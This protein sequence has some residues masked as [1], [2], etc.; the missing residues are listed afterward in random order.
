MC[1]IAGILDLDGAPVPQEQIAAMTACLAHRGPDDERF[2]V[3]GN[4]A[5]GHTRL[6]IIDPNGSFQ[7]MSSA[8]GRFSIT[9]NGEILNYRQLRR[10]LDYPFSTDGD[11]E[12]LLALFARYGPQGA[13][14]LRGQYAYAVYDR[15]T[16]ELHLVRDRL[17]ILPLYYVPDGR[18]ILFASEIK[19]L[20]AVIGQRGVD[21]DSVYDYLVHR[22][23]P[24][25]YT[26]FDGIRKLLPGHRLRIRPGGEI[27]ELA[28]WRVPND[29]AR[30]AISP[31]SAVEL[32][33][34]TL[35]ESVRDALVADVPVGA[36]LSG[37]LDSSL[38]VAVASQ[39][40]NGEPLKTY[41]AGFGDPR[42]ELPYARRVSQLLGT[43][44]HE[45]VLEP[46]DF[47]DAW[48]PLTWHRDAPMS[49]PA[50]VAVH[51][52]AQL[53]RTDVKVILSGE[54]SDELFAGYPKYRLAKLADG[55]DAVPAALRHGLFGALLRHVPPRMT[56]LEA[57]LRAVLADSRGD[58]LRSWFSPFGD[59]ER[60]SLFGR[61]QR[62][63]SPWYE[64]A[65]GDA[66]RR[67]LYADL[68][69]WLPDN[70]LERGD[71]MSMAASLELRPPFLDVRLVELAFRLP[72][73]VKLRRGTSKWVV[74]QVAARRLPD[75]IVHRR[76]VGFTVPLDA[77]FRGGLRTMAW[78]MLD[79]DTSFAATIFD[80]ASLRQ[81]L[82]SHDEG[83]R[84]EHMRLWTLLG[85]EVWH[86]VFFGAS[87]VAASAPSD[88]HRPQ[89]GGV[90]L[91][92]LNVQSE[93][94]G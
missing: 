29:P 57:P 11:T 74:K 3:S 5:F 49:E 25:P 61:P 32:V 27:D 78:D 67:M 82:R 18:R 72:S 92:P 53:A 7:P 9:F 80:R 23:V 47:I 8:D 10:G 33:D 39:L 63:S 71:R 43:E 17:G 69:G 66:V 44:H 35:T 16:G 1:G 13:Q 90:A 84:S 2:W 55:A 21:R 41:S 77:W 64:D 65:R 40:R 22:S 59:Q 85:L 68:H 15:D 79:S 75:E 14:R 42:D 20:L 36:Y 81:L 91:S 34:K 86:E 58:R 88:R 94:R 50:D 46:G 54:G 45:V 89:P 60:Q 12:V 76:K 56:R 62:R 52:L 48:R 28:Y 51:R 83:R 31:K 37:G 87:R 38:I 6:S 93:V 19:A 4:V 73:S 30:Q 70:L 26:L 24:A